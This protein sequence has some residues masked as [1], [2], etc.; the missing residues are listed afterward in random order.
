MR[1]RLLAAAGV[2]VL[3]LAVALPVARAVVP[4]GKNQSLDWW[5]PVKYDQ[6]GR[7]QPQPATAPDGSAVYAS[8]EVVTVKVHFVDGVKN[9]DV[10]LQPDAG[11]APSTCHEDIAQ[12][13]GKY[14]TDIYISCPWDTTRAVDRTLDQPTPGGAAGDQN[15]QRHWHLSD[16]GLSLNG[17]YSIQVIA[18]SA[19]QA[20]CGVLTCSPATQ[21]QSFELYQD[22]AAKRWR[23]IYVTNGV[24]N[25][26]G[27]NNSY[28]PATNRINVTWAP[29][30]EPDVT[31]MVQEK[32]GD[33]KWSDGVSVPGSATNY[34]RTID[35]PGKYQYQV[36]AVRPA[37]TAD[38][39]KAAA[40]TKTSSYVA[41]GAVDIA[42]VTPPTTAGANGADGAADGGDPGVFIPGD[43]PPSTAP[44]SHVAAPAKGTSA[45]GRS[46]GPSSGSRPSGT[47]GRSTGATGGGGTVPGEAEGEGP[48]GGFSST[49]PYQAQDGSAQD[50]LGD[51][52]EEQP[53]SMSKLVNVPRPHDARALLVPV[54]LG[55][56]MFVFAMQLKVLFRSRPAM[57]NAADDFDDFDE[58]MRY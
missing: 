16:H 32:V 12:D 38:T 1:R 46:S 3:G 39:G 52:S 49:L 21:P 35:Q 33:G 58:W 11:G 14:P 24:A 56:L 44:G 53:E 48:D 50:G 4:D 5:T 54:A 17:R 13:N 6:Q 30:P 37:P 15:L 18:Q 2:A 43:A 42:Q 7:A 20:Q 31:Y 28:D 23:Q 40:A 55:L 10:R 26:T 34:V 9:W 41:T 8:D 25:P 57:A 51:G 19:G 22:P 29:N 27:V 47:A 36:A 45:A